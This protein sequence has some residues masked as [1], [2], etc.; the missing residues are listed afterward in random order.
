MK[1]DMPA[2][3]SGGKTSTGKS[4]DGK[5]KTQPVKKDSKSRKRMVIEEV[6][7]DEETPS[8]KGKGL[9]VGGFC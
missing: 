6:E 1:K 2:R 3:D 4:S 5:N 8:T 9:L 7:S